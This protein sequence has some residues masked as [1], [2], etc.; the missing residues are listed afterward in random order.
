[1]FDDST[2]FPS[3]TLGADLAGHCKEE[4][5]DEEQQAREEMMDRVSGS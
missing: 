3:I 4:E 1:M 2:I 5:A